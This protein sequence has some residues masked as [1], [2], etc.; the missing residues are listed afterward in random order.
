VDVADVISTSG[1]GGETIDKAVLDMVDEWGRER[2][3]R[4]ERK[5][6]GE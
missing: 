1:R 3:R 5:P 6:K 4:C 2:Q